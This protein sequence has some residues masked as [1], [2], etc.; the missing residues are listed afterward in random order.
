VAELFVQRPTDACA[1]FV[2]HKNG[3]RLDAAAANLEWIT[4]SQNSI[5]AHDTGL[6]KN[7][8][9]VS[10][11]TIDGSCIM[12]YD[13]ITAAAKR[14]GISRSAISHCISGNHKTAGGFFWK[15]KS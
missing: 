10:Q 13:S 9:K 15:A 7:R 2:N 1:V 8:V 3:D 4:P 14:L 6:L 12:E 5:H 11:M